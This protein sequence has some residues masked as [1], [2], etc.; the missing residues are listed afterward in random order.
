MDKKLAESI[1][2]VWGIGRSKY[3]PGTLGS[4]VAILF[5]A[6]YFYIFFYICNVSNIELATIKIHYSYY[7]K[8][9]VMYIIITIFFSI[10]GYYATKY[11]LL[12]TT[13]ADPQEVVIDEV[14]GQMLTIF[15]TFLFTGIF[16]Y[17]NKNVVL[18]HSL[19]TIK[20][21]F[22]FVLLPFITFRAYDIIKPWPINWLDKNIDGAL[23]VM[24]DDIAAA[25]LASLS[26]YILVSLMAN[27]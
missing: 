27:Q 19:M 13:T 26:V 8:C 17:S 24:I 23:G 20:Y 15:L 21:F 4:M 3:M 14:V 25:F 1:A 2:T 18:L 11:Y 5:S 7:Y 16:L 22:L 9:I 6:I 10:I 12:T